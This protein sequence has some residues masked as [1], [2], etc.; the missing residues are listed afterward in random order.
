MSDRLEQ[1]HGLADNA[2]T[3]AQQAEA[4]AMLKQDSTAHAEYEWAVVLKDQLRSKCVQPKSEECW[5]RVT[6]QLDA[7]D[8]TKKAERFVG[9]YS[10]GLACVFVIAIVSA[11]VFNRVNG[12]EEVST[13][14]IA[15]LVN[16]MAPITRPA[17][18]PEAQRE[19][20]NRMGAVPVEVDQLEVVGYNYGKMMGR[21]AATF[22]LMDRTGA[23]ELMMIDGKITVDSMDSNRSGIYSHGYINNAPCLV[24]NEDGFGF[25]L[26]G[27]R[28][29]LELIDAADQL[30]GQR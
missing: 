16:G 28:S 5:G 17:S 22:A 7:I 27:R 4:I 12:G 2:L 26:S 1:A 29:S 9:R 6:A 13:R 14:A 3:D 19:L 10:W 15:G 11:A 20:Q 18:A 24:W 8:R 25:I 21:D 23:L 30:R